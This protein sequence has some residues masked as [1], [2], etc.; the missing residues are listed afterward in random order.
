[1]KVWKLTVTSAAGSFK[2][3]VEA[4]NRGDALD[5]MYSLVRFG[6][7]LFAKLTDGE[8]FEAYTYRAELDDW[9]SF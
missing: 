4:T 6:I 7:D 2:A 8:T 5:V 9:T 3:N 1:M